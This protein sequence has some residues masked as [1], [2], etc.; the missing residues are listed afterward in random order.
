ASLFN[1]ARDESMVRSPTDV[2]LS[3][4]LTRLIGFRLQ[5]ISGTLER[6]DGFRELVDE[7]LMGRIQRGQRGLIEG[8]GV[9]EEKAEILAARGGYVVSAAIDGCSR[10]F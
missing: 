10:R 3:R 8:Y 7:R 2:G 4:G 1:P 9:T 6:L 5:Q